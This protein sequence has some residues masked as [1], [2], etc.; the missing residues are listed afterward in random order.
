MTSPDPVLLDVQGRIARLTLNRPDKLNAVDSGM[1]TGLTRHLCALEEDRG[2]QV[3]VLA[4]AGRSFC[5]GNDLRQPGSPDAEYYELYDALRRS[6][7]AIIVRIQGHCAG[8]GLQMA[9]LADLRIAAASAKIG[10]VE[11]NVGYPVLIG[12]ALLE[13]VC[14]EAAMKRLVLLGDFVSGPEAVR[15]NLAT[16]VV[17]DVALDARVAEIAEGLAGRAE[18]AIRLTRQC[19]SHFSEQ[20]FEAIMTYARALREREPGARTPVL[21][22]RL[23]RA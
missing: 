21:P 2:V 1:R 8:A 3:I 10:M 13:A 12:S 5:A 20:R 11:F 16:E 23:K 22:E 6:T 9:L 14:G 4:G 18:A 7:K 17:E 19:W 15:L